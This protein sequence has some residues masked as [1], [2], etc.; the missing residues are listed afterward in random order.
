[1]N[2]FIAKFLGTGPLAAYHREQRPE[3]NGHPWPRLHRY[4]YTH[5]LSPVCWRCRICWISPA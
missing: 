4:T 1:M 3:S 5:M 2:N